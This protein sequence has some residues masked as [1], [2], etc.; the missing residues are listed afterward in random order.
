MRRALESM[1]VD[2]SGYG[3]VRVDESRYV[4]GERFER[5]AGRLAVEELS[6]TQIRFHRGGEIGRRSAQSGGDLSLAADARV[7]DLRLGNFDARAEV[8]LVASVL[9]IELRGPVLA[10]R[11]KI[12]EAKPARREPRGA[13]E[14]E[15]SAGGPVEHRSVR[16]EFRRMRVDGGI[17]RA[18][19]W[20]AVQIGGDAR[21]ALKRAARE[22][23]EAA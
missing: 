11:Q 9:A 10:A 1:A 12:G 13:R 22:Q 20:R 6:L 17:Q 19:A 4:I 7:E 5:D 21:F 8:H 23:R 18:I 3:R 2:I 15:R 14:V 16:R